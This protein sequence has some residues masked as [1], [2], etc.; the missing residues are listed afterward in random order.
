MIPVYLISEMPRKPATL[1][2]SQAYV[3]LMLGRCA[4]Y[5]STF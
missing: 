4:C 3:Q 2:A 1:Y 5:K